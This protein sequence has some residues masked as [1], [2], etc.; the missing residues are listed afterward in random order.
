[1]RKALN[2]YVPGAGEG[3][4]S[5]QVKLAGTALGLSLLALTLGGCS[6]IFGM[7]S[8]GGCSARDMPKIRKVEEVFL[9]LTPSISGSVIA[10]D[11]DSGAPPYLDISGSNWTNLA[12]QLRSHG[13]TSGEK[14]I[15]CPS[16]KNA[17]PFTVSMS[18]SD[19]AYNPPPIT[20]TLD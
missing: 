12:Q 1:M 9:S 20:V 15:R 4:M 14:V 18:E 6:A 7:S 2:P 8:D 16:V 5:I 17:P 3:E 13:C 10:V 11:C 19:A